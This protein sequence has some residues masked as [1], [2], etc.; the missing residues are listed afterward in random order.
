MISGVFDGSGDDTDVSNVV[1]V[2]SLPAIAGFTVK[3]RAIMADKAR[4]AEIILVLGFLMIWGPP[5]I[6]HS[7]NTAGA[8]QHGWPPLFY[9]IHSLWFGTSP[10][11][12]SWPN[13][14]IVI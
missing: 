13:L 14:L 4:V 7:L 1:L 8:A 3:I 12:F 5:L 11:S 6:L 10:E 2:V 9:S